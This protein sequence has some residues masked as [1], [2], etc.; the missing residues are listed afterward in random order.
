MA[1][2]L[3]PKNIPYNRTTLM[4]ADANTADVLF[5][6]DITDANE[7]PRRQVYLMASFTSWEQIEMVR[8]DDVYRGTY[9][10]LLVRD[11]PL[12]TGTLH[13]YRFVADGFDV[14]DEDFSSEGNPV[15]SEERN[16]ILEISTE[17]LFGRPTLEESDD[18]LVRGGGGLRVK[19]PWAVPKRALRS[20]QTRGK[21]SVY[22]PSEMVKICKMYEKHK[23]ELSHR[24]KRPRRSRR[25]RR[26]DG[27]ALGRKRAFEASSRKRKSGPK[28]A[29]T[30]SQ[31]AKTSLRKPPVDGAQAGSLAL[32][33][34]KSVH[35]VEE[36]VLGI[37]KAAREEAGVKPRFFG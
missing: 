9:F 34:G 33:L 3:K 21:S 27:I 2:Q 23:E 36:E 15:F 18:D 37:L 11:I 4:R 12:S 35:E 16:N 13:R 14:V 25:A 29:A 31:F 10:H 6:F 19:L 1:L 17:F 24:V 7:K 26:E 20:R 22:L 32:C 30:Y 8:V 5:F 28:N